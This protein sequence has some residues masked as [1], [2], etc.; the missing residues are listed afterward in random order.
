MQSF[1]VHSLRP[2]GSKEVPFEARSVPFQP[3]RVASRRTPVVSTMSVPTCECKRHYLL[4]D[5]ITSAPEVLK[6]SFSV[7][8]AC[9]CAA[10]PA[11]TWA[12]RSTVDTAR[13]RW[14]YNGY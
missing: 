13:V 10:G 1:D 14:E 11:R 4:F 9:V 2:S 5:A 6:G 12:L 7:A 3:S 8:F